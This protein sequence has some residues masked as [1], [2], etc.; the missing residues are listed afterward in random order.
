MGNTV[1]TSSQNP[2]IPSG[3]T[4]TPVISGSSPANN[5]VVNTGTALSVNG[6]LTVAGNLTNNG[7]I[8]GTGTLTFNGTGTTQLLTNN[9]S[10]TLNNLT[11]N[12]SAGTTVKL[13]GAL[14]V[15][16]SVTVTQG[17]LD[18][19]NQP[20]VLV[21]TAVGTG[22]IGAVT[23]SNLLNAT[24]VTQ[25]RYLDPATATTTGTY[26][27]LGTP[28]K[29]QTLNSYKSAGV[30]LIGFPGASYTGSGYKPSAWY[31]DPTS[32][33]L[34][35]NNVIQ[36]SQGWTA[37]TSA[38][39][40]VDP[41]TGIRLFV[42]K[43]FLGAAIALTGTV[44]QGNIT[45]PLKYCTSG[46]SYQSSGTANG[47]NLI[48]NPYPS[49]IDWS[50]ISSS[51]RPNIDD[52]IYIFRH[53]KVGYA[54]YV[55]G[56]AAGVSGASNVIASS[57]AFFVRANS[58]GASVTFKESNKVSSGPSFLRRAA[59]AQLIRINISA[60]RN[61]ETY[62][63]DAV[64]RFSDLATRGFDGQL[65]A[66]KLFGNVINVSTKSNSDYYSI[67]AIPMP[68]VTDSINLVANSTSVGSC[69][70]TF[71]DM[72]SLPAGI[73]V[74]L[75]D[76]YLGTTTLVSNQDIY[77]YSVT[78]DT[79]SNSVG[80]FVLVFAPSSVTGINVQAKAAHFRAFPNPST[81]NNLQVSFYAFDS[82]TFTLSI[83]D[84]L[85]QEVYT[86]TLQGPANKVNTQSLNV[87]LSSGVYTIVCKTNNSILKQQLV[88]NK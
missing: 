17:T 47:F 48:S 87:D 50:S 5:I 49:E 64:V 28:I 66:V 40:L 83:V 62:S 59:N 29:G 23:T 32:A 30:Y 9:S 45:V 84:V 13:I 81:G 54:T 76:K 57:Q 33:D 15:S 3:T 77:N 36:S 11:I 2:I 88:V 63:E 20:L 26:A 61:G 24:Q 86:T 4:N 42:Q 37:A 38:T 18:L 8:N 80:R 31:Y 82:E 55:G 25:Q 12:T 39:N 27:F 85:G 74:Y 21:S 71:S 72:E 53:K 34:T 67:N 52:A 14:N 78:V 19:N 70:F 65:D 22:R 44:Q 73:T 75:K 60:D 51:D 16:G 43:S 6:T 41:G 56:V 79:L 35:V 69:K 68:I 10:A 58:A 7:T 1:P 46:C